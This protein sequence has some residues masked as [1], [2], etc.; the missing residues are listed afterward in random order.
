MKEAD[1]D[2]TLMQEDAQRAGLRELK[3]K[4]KQHHKGL[5]TFK[6]EKQQKKEKT[7]TYH[8]GASMQMWLRLNQAIWS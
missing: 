7:V 3:S 5:K 6:K 8:C 1:A 2:T 4:R